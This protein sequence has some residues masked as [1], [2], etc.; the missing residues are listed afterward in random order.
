MNTGQQLGTLQIMLEKKKKSKPEAVFKCKAMNCAIRKGM[1]T[2]KDQCKMVEE[3]MAQGDSKKV[4]RLLKTLTK[5][6][7]HRI[8]IIKDSNGHL[9]TE[10]CCTRLM[11]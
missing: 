7:Q 4:H 5:S 3:G 2:G 6:T 8:S 1:Q 9:L 10:N 11:D